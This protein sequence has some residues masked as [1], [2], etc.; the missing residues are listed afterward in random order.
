MSSKFI[1]LDMFMAGSWSDH[2]CFFQGYIDSA[3]AWARILMDS[4]ILR[5]TRADFHGAAGLARRP[6]PP[7]I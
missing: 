1:S 5:G 2:S 3:L 4:V 6:C 7:H